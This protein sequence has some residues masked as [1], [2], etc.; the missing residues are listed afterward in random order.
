[1]SKKWLFFD[2]FGV[3]IDSLVTEGRNFKIS[4]AQIQEIQEK[5]FNKIDRGE[6]SD[7]E[8][9]KKL[10]KIVGCPG[11][12][13]IQEVFVEKA[14]VN[15]ELT[16]WIR[17]NSDKYH[18]ALL[19]NAAPLYLDPIFQ[20]HDLKSLFEKMFISYDLKITKPSPSIYTTALEK[21]GCK[22]SNAIMID[23]RIDNIT[24]ARNVGMHGVVFENTRDAIAQIETIFPN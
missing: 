8:A 14:T 18:I 12:E 24:S 5:V 23:D 4:T 19:S 6:M 9:L 7:E 16:D 22:P 10:S 1:M 21:C 20:Y 11:A 13:F 17:Q 2:C 15:I 3:L